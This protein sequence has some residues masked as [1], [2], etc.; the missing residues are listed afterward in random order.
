MRILLV[1]PNMTGEV[2][3]LMLDT[4][5]AAASPGVELV[6]VT[7]SRGL[8]YISSRAEAQIGGVVALEMLADAGS[9]YDAA[10]V[11]AFGDPGLWAAKELFDF[12]VIGISEAAMLTACMLGGRFLIVTFTTAM[13]GWYQ[14]CVAMHGLENRCA[15]IVALD[16]PI[17]PLHE[18]GERHGEALIAFANTEAIARDAASVILA[19]APLT[20][21]A[22]RVRERSP[23]P[24]VD[25]MVAAVRQAETIAALR[26]KKATQGS[27]R[28]P[29]GK[30]S[31]GLHG[32]LTQVLRGNDAARS[33]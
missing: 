12:P 22:G 32:T 18:V 28:R 1:N 25:P 4:A 23:V 27:F 26:T 17:G 3:S 19:G 15:G 21:L 6:G 30:A 11:A 14:D 20:G 7:A 29:A 2:T 5:R 13:R 33:E 24:L 16:C 31:F 9:G 8:P 10:I